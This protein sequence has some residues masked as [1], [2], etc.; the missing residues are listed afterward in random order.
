MS[1]TPEPGW[2]LAAALVVLVVIAVVAATAGGMRIRRD[3]V[4]ACIR[5]VAQ[6]AVVSLA[7]TAVLSHL[8]WSA[9]FA[10][11]MFAVAAWTSAERIGAPRDVA[12]VAAAIAAGVA[13]VLALLLGSGVIPRTG[14]ALV[15]T[16]GIVIGGAM[17]ANTL[18]G[19]RAFDE[20]RSQTGVYEAALAIGL[21]RREAT[22]EVVQPTTPEAL[23]PVLDQTRTVGLVTLPGA[24]VGV[25][26]GGGTP[27][28]AGAAQVMVLVGLVAAE[29][30]VALVLTHLIATRRVL[31]P[32]LR[33][34]LA[35]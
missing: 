31:P 15:P 13:P 1:S 16:A 4:V 22:L 5:A 24:Y 26:L 27:L 2:P 14:A 11:L 34:D 18:T 7:I 32:R 9:A 25:L 30:V 10:F 23:T 12:W 35:H 28:E 33:S 29:T 17:T 21:P 6:L 20:L 19:R 8:S 3:I